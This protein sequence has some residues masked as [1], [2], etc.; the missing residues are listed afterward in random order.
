VEVRVTGTERRAEPHNREQSRPFLTAQ[1]RNLLMLHWE[2]DPKLL[3][4]RVPV[5]TT[6]D[7]W[8]GKA[9]VGLIGFQFLDTKILGTPVPF[10]QDFEEVNLRFYV[11]RVVGEEVRSAVV[12]ICECVPRQLVGG[13]ARLLY[14]E[15]YMV[16][17][18]KSAVRADPAPDVQYSWQTKNRWNLMSARAT[19]SG[20]PPKARTLDEF[21]TLR[22]W[23]YNGKPG[24]DTLEYKVDHPR[25][26]I[27]RAEDVRFDADLESLCGA[28]LSRQLTTPVSA[29]LADGSPVTIHWRTRIA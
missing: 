2:V 7:L 29:I 13:M 11:R 20:E 19:G 8:Q 6:L 22:N 3:I 18:M 15:P 9:Y 24:S 12:F 28:E 17:P 10:H 14:R 16:V 26:N 25:W 21:L 5:G 1:W 4:D 23:G 27:W